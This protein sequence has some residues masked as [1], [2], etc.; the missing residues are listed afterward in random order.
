MRWA[1]L[2]ASCVWWNGEGSSRALRAAG[3]ATSGSWGMG[4]FRVSI[5]QGCESAIPV[6]LFMSHFWLM[7]EDWSMCWWFWYTKWMADSNSQGNASP[8]RMKWPIRTISYVTDG[9]L[10]AVDGWMYRPFLKLLQNA[11]PLSVPGR[12]GTDWGQHE[13]RLRKSGF[14]YTSGWLTREGNASPPRM[15]WPIR[16]ISYVTDGWLL[17]VD[18]VMRRP[19]LKLLQKASPL[20]VPGRMALIEGSMKCVSVGQLSES[21]HAITILVSIPS[22]VG[23]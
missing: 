19:F 9:W 7:R 12:N 8:T 11:S 14:W 10:L 13:V 5:G 2:A 16:T 20:S 1:L 18:G 17:A 15:K 3:V 21:W 4:S 22:C 6:C 23:E